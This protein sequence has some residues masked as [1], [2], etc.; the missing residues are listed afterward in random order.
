MAEHGEHAAFFASLPA[1]NFEPWELT[2]R[3]VLM[4][5]LRSRPGSFPLTEWI[6]HR[7]GGEIETISNRRGGHDI[8]FYNERKLG[9]VQEPRGVEKPTSDL[10]SQP[11]W[12][13]PGES[14]KTHNGWMRQDVH[15]ESAQTSEKSTTSWNHDKSSRGEQPEI[16]EFMNQLPQGELT[17][18]EESLRAAVME[19]MHTHTGVHRCISSAKQDRNVCRKVAAVLPPYIPLETWIGRRMKDE[20]WCTR[21]SHGDVE[22]MTIDERAAARQELDDKKEIFFAKLPPDEFTREEE[23]LRQALIAFLDQ[24]AGIGSPELTD[25]ASDPEVRLC[26]VALLGEGD[27]VLVRGRKKRVNR[28]TLREWI[29]RRI[30]DDIE[31]K[32][33][34][35]GSMRIG[36]RGQVDTQLRP[37]QRDKEAK[38]VEF[39]SAL[40]SDTFNRDEGKLRDALFAFIDRWERSEGSPRLTDI[41]LDPEVTSFR[42]AFMPVT[43]SQHAQIPL[44]KWI[45]Y[46]LG[47]DIECHMDDVGNLRVDRLG[48]LNLLSASATTTPHS[49]PIK[50]ARRG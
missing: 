34:T 21:T 48:C 24:W 49:R 33:D 8:R 44:H 46:R 17:Q 47:E 13:S 42:K 30:D 25:A 41:A 18:S 38:F 20:I 22:L 19:Y 1:D 6:D 7:I 9:S 32:M 29:E 43:Y 45:E 10:L 36:M 28:V 12:R 31:C 11:P 39:L 5:R 14:T 4:D 15:R 35:M 2:L 37:E 3:D 16:T 27:I 40:P 23:N 26:Q 50:Q